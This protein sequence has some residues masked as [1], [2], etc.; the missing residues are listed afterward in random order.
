M[1]NLKI[2]LIE[3]NLT[4]ARQLIEFF[5]GHKWVVDYAQT[6][7]LGVNL[8]A[9]NIYD[10]VLLDLNLPDIDGLDVCQKIK[11]GAQCNT[12]ILMLTARDAFEDKVRGF[13]RG[14]DDYV[15][16]PFE[17]RELV[18]RCQALSRRQN[19]H[20][21]K[22]I[23][24]A[25][26]QLDLQDKMASRQGV[27]LSLTNIGFSILS[28]LAQAYPQ[29]VSRSVLIHKIWGD[30]PPES[31]ALKSHIYSLRAALDKP[32][33]RPMLVTINNVGYRLK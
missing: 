22:Q 31:D 1:K 16:K 5:A 15:T 6:G 27:A 25:D 10:V 8:A 2:L 17:M 4:I 18:L 30:D 33:E 26:L 20:I 12:P 19:L 13:E 3:D 21:N 11:D 9:E 29:A 14:A 24:I 23:V 28:V 32:F 7:T